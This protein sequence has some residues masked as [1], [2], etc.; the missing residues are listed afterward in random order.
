MLN[1]IH[2]TK[3]KHSFQSVSQ[4]GVK[5]KGSGVF[6]ER[7]NTKMFQQINK[8]WTLEKWSIKTNQILV[9]NQQKTICTEFLCSKAVI[10]LKIIK[11]TFSLL[12]DS[13][14]IS[15]LLSKIK[16]IF[17]KQTQQQIIQ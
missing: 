8:L 4:R 9:Q 16:R 11:R 14:I 15:K 3:W 13:Q 5:S 12:F 10:I 6:N 2:K 17:M 7:E 1:K